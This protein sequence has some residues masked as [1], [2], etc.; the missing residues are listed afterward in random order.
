MAK[1]YGSEVHLNLPRYVKLHQ[2]QS[3]KD[4]HGQK[5]E[6]LSP[7]RLRGPA[8]MLRPAAPLKAAGSAI[9]AWES[10]KGGLDCLNDR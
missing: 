4:I 2:T 5:I 1:Q 7:M 8:G 10:S 3:P 9:N 6:G